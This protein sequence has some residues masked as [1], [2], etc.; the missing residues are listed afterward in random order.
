MGPAD[1]N[2]PRVGLPTLAIDECHLA[3]NR[4]APS[5][6][7]SHGWRLVDREMHN[8]LCPLDRLRRASCL[9]NQSVKHRRIARR[10]IREQRVAADN[11]RLD[12]D[13]QPIAAHA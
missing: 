10:D 4:S 8:D 6:K 3:C 7:L 12:L 9:G 11:E 1:G 13:S 2:P 5:P